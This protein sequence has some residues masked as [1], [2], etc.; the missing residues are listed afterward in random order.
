M[1]MSIN[2]QPTLQGSLIKLR[3]LQESD[4]DE[5]YSVASDSLIWEQHPANDRY[6]RSVFEKFFDDAMKSG[7]AFVAIDLKEN[8]IIGSSRYNDYDA[9]QKSIEIG[10][11][12]LARSYWGGSY[13][14]EMKQLMLQHAF[15]FVDAVNFVIG[16]DNIRSQKA[17]KKIGGVKVASK[18]DENGEERVIYQITSLSE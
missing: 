1:T 8:K 14:G 15:Q 2:L 9:E 13:N 5:V 10:W 18:Y 16:P 3:P 11:S 12:F 4:F 6:Q 17:V 7:G